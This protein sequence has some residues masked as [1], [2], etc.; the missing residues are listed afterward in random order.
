[1]IHLFHQGHLGTDV[2]AFR[3]MFAASG[4]R[5]MAGIATEKEGTVPA[6]PRVRLVPL[7]TD[8]N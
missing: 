8:R 3:D 1:M 6:V 4:A 2:Q 5:L 7:E